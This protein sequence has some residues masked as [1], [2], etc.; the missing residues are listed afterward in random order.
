M[1]SKYLVLVAIVSGFIPGAQPAAMAAELVPNHAAEVSS[2][3][4]ALNSQDSD[5][6][7]NAKLQLLRPE[8]GP[9]LKAHSSE[10]IAALQSDWESEES[11]RLL[12]RLDLPSD[13][14]DRL[15]NSVHVPDAVRARLGDSQA[16][17]RVISA[18]EGAHGFESHHSAAANLAYVE[19]PGSLAALAHGLSSREVIQDVHGN[20]VSVPLLL[21]QAYGNMHPDEPLFSSS[22]YM[23]HANVTPQEFLQPEHQAYLRQ[24]EARLLARDQLHVTINPPFLLNTDKVEKYR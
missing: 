12:G 6:R 18:F 9:W 3:A 19:S 11:A 10:I 21:I 1:K 22:E 23:K 2:A 20:D 13:L 17:Q 16:E 4:Q 24:L 8:A 7:L 5:A 15:R 14:A